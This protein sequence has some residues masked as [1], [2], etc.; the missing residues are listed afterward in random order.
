M[1][2]NIILWT[3]VGL[4]L[5]ALLIGGIFL[6]HTLTYPFK[7]LDIDGVK[8]AEIPKEAVIE[9]K[10]AGKGPELK[11]LQKEGF[12]LYFD[13]IAE[14][15]PGMGSVM[16]T[17]AEQDAREQL[18]RYLN[19]VVTDFQQRAQGVLQSSTTGTDNDKVVSVANNVFKNVSSNF[20]KTIQTGAEVVAKYYVMKAGRIEYH[21]V[22]VYNPKTAFSLL[23]QQSYLIEQLGDQG[24]E[25]YENLNKVLEEAFKNTPSK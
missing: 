22:L 14:G 11:Q 19:S 5:V 3:G 2:N 17:Q 15:A 24:K 1:D 4:G 16:Y 7:P 20:A 10:K 23:Q 8:I 12:L 21:S 18:A 25:F 9:F 6:Y 13:G